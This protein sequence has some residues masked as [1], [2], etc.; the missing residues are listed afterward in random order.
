[1]QGVITD[2]LFPQS[3]EVR[4]SAEESRRETMR[5]AGR[6]QLTVLRSGLWVPLAAACSTCVA[7]RKKP[8]VEKNLQP[9]DEGVAAANPHAVHLGGITIPAN[10]REARLT[11]TRRQKEDGNGGE[12]DQEG[13]RCLMCKHGQGQL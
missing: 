6:L 4:V 5:Q 13:T 10:Q 2:L 12:M 3:G 1:M 9:R 8:P 11:W 7:D